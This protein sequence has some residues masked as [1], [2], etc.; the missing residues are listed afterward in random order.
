M[1]DWWWKVGFTPQ[2]IRHVCPYGHFSSLGVISIWVLCLESASWGTH[3][4]GTFQN[5]P[6]FRPLSTTSGKEPLWFNPSFSCMSDQITVNAKYKTQY[7]DDQVSETSNECIQKP[8]WVL[9]INDMPSDQERPPRWKNH[10]AEEWVCT[11]VVHIASTSSLFVD[12]VYLA[13]TVIWSDVNLYVFVGVCTALNV[14]A[15]T[16]YVI[17]FLTA[18]FQFLLNNANEELPSRCFHHLRINYLL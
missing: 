12:V 7:I 8:P 13:V 5:Y 18:Q 17:C 10:P 9:L 6:F 14:R 3:T 15:L 4:L 2:A 11:A 16:C 1:T